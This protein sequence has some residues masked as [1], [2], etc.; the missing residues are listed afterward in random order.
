MIDQFP[1][2]VVADDIYTTWEAAIQGYRSAIADV[3]VTEFRTPENM[4][5]LFGHKA[6][7]AC[8]YFREIFRFIPELSRMG[9]P[10]R[11]VVLFRMGQML[12]LPSLSA[13]IFLIALHW[14]WTAWLP[15]FNWSAWLIPAGVFTFFL[16]WLMKVYNFR[17]LQVLSLALL[18]D[19]ILLA[20][21][22]I[23]PFFTQTASY[24]KVGARAPVER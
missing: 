23:Y 1:A 4:R 10:A 15:I 19:V 18:I 13:I 17:P 21:L 11:S 3:N 5:Q 7:K 8:A 24:P 20:S 14:I 9:R 22:V 16:F 2:D 12:I 6:R